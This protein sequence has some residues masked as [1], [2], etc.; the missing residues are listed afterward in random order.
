MRL[1]NLISVTLAAT[2]LLATAGCSNDIPDPDPPRAQNDNAELPEGVP[3]YSSGVTEET[4][5]VEPDGTV[6]VKKVTS[7]DTS[8]VVEYFNEKLASDGWSIQDQQSFQ[9]FDGDVT[10]WVAF[11]DGVRCDV[12]MQVYGDD[13]PILIEYRAK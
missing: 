12:K 11:R 3:V 4:A 5:T 8:T 10:A 9:N 2:L 13:G 6:V 1:A 7:D